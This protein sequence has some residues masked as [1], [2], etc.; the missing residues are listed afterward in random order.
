MSLKL[1]KITDYL[2]GVKSIGMAGHI[3]PDGDCVGSCMGLYTYLRHQFKDIEVDLYMEPISDKFKFLKYTDEIKNEYQGDKVYD[4]FISL[5]SS[6]VDRLGN[7]RPYFE[8]AKRTMCIDHHISNTAFAGDNVVYTKASSASEVVYGLLDEDK[9]DYDVACALYLGIVHDSGVFKYSNTSAQTMC[10]AGKLMEKGIPFTQIIDNTF[11]TKT[12]VQNQILGRALLESVMFYDGKCIFSVVKKDEFEFYNI[13]NKDLDG[14]V[15]QLRI[16]KGVECAI[17]LYEV[18][19][20]EYKVSLRS[21]EIVDVSAIATHFGGGGHVKA[22][23]F[24]MKGNVYDVINNISE[25]IE[26]QLGA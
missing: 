23:G 20:L 8:S 10:I 13:T 15:E 1:E 12:Y 16:T 2:N 18:E 21:N 26:L 19:K 6:D 24:N 11:Y 9:V 14:I 4:L 5:D 3:N 22:A 7:F 25:Q 17:F